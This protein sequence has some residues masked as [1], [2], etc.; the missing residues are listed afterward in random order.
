ML[1]AVE[2]DNEGLLGANEIGHER[3]E[4]NLSAEFQAKEAAVAQPRP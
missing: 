2:F 1:T 3:P 4:R